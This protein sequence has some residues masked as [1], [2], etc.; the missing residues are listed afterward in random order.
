MTPLTYTD[1]EDLKQKVPDA[2]A[3]GDG[4]SFVLLDMVYSD[5]EKI[6]LPEWARITRAMPTP[7]GV[8][9]KDITLKVDNQGEIAIASQSMCFVPGVSIADDPDNVGGR[10][11]VFQRPT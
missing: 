11:L 6:P 1:I 9:L 5:A 7:A 2:I 3:I 8:V 10:R 4:D